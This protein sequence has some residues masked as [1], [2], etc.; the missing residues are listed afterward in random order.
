MRR[1]ATTAAGLFIVLAAALTACGRS[2]GS[3][4]ARAVPSVSPA[5]PALSYV[6]I[7]ASETLGFGA[8]DPVSQAWTQVFYRTALPRAATLVNLGIPGATAQE[9]LLREVPE[10]ARLRPDIVTVWLN[11]NDLIRGVPPDDY[12]RQITS[13][14]EGLR[15]AGSPTI[16]VANT[17]PL[18]RLPRFAMCLPFSPAP[19]GECDQT[20]PL[21]AEELDAMVMAYNSAISEAA[22]RAGAIVVDLH[23]LGMVAQ[24]QGTDLELVSRDGFHPSTAGHL[25]IGRAFARALPAIEGGG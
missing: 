11:V 25:A 9:A 17:P 14:L 6:A 21:T 5:G 19:G 23:A 10:A 4:G 16:L 8:D 24:R 1:T 2:S 15:Q 13:L 22:A 18:G 7:G 3:I 20:R 12:R